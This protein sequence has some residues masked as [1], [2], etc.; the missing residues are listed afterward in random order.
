MKNLTFLFVFLMASGSYLLGQAPGAGNAIDFGTN[1]TGSTGYLT[2][3]DNP[4]LNPDSTFTLEAWIKADSWATQ[5]WAGVI[6]S[7]DG[8][9]AGEKGYTLRCGAGGRLSANFG[10]NPGWKEALSAPI[11]QLNTWYHVASVYDGTT[12]RAYINGMEVASFAYTGGMS[13]SAYDIRIGSITYTAGGIRSFDGKIDEVRIWDTHLSESTLRN[14]MCR[15]LNSTHPYDTSLVL[16]LRM[17]EGAGL[18]TADQ[19]SNTFTATINSGAPWLTSGAALGDM[20]WNDYA[21]PMTL[22]DFP[23]TNLG[24][25]VDNVTGSPDGMHLYRVDNTPNTDSLNGSGTP[26]DTSQYWGVFLTGGSTPGYSMTYS[27]GGNSRVGT[28]N[29][30][31]VSLA[32]RDDNAAT[33]W[34]DQ[35]ANLNLTLNELTLTG[36]SSRQEYTLGFSNSGLPLTASGPTR[37]CEMDSVQLLASLSPNQNYQ[38]LVNGT[39]VS[40]ATDSSLTVF[41]SGTYQVVTNSGGCIDTSSSTAIVIDSLPIL[42]L[43]VPSTFCVDGLPFL[44]VANI[45]GGTYSGP[46]I[47]ANGT[48]SPFSAGVGTHSISYQFTTSRGC[49]SSTSY[50]VTVNPLPVVGLAAI[51]T[52]CSANAPFTL[53]QGSP[54]GGVYSGNGVMSNVFDPSAAGAG[55]HNIIYSFTDGNGCTETASRTVS[56]NN[57]PSVT[58]GS[59]NAICENSPTFILGGGNP[60]GGTYSGPGVVSGAI[61]DASVSGAG[62]HAITY[63]YS[64]MTGCADSATA[65]ILVSGLPNVTHSPLASVCSDASAFQLSGGMPTGGSY[66]GPG[67]VGGMFDPASLTPGSFQIQ[68][69][70]TDATGCSNSVLASITL[71]PK[72]P[73]PTITSSAGILSSSIAAS[74]QWYDANGPL[75]GATTQGI[76]PGQSG[77]YYVLI[78]DANGCTNRSDDFNFI[79]ASIDLLKAG[80]VSLFPNPSAGVF[81]LTSELD[82]R[83]IQIWNA[84]GQLCW[85]KELNHESETQIDLGHFPAGMYLIQVTTTEG[86]LIGK[87]V[88]E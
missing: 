35:M 53:T 81:H 64:D 83:E 63:V 47:I 60:S 37:F 28:T 85:K 75:N 12:L 46:G 33:L 39:P 49:T 32:G 15:K 36:T 10:T 72:P 51:G 11:M 22:M 70:Y 17:D 18:T 66:S 87:M 80:G 38:W 50:S 43:A 16:N 25:L 86:I 19:S 65:M 8:W 45:P 84:T 77:I 26:V 76:T 62:L 2:I 7:K 61:F 29:E 9:G 21:A 52:Y 5:A 40:G 88:K 23:A 56:V 44:V 67:I 82:L 79:S 27:Y 57:G 1:A 41:L 42:S 73:K 3:P 69:N 4:Q 31:K 48:F 54:A 20:S 30:C 74:Y 55:V 24:V 13:N 78:T 58:L 71:L 59:F 6:I 34:L 68:Y 14:W